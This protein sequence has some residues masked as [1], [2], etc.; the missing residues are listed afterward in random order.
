[1]LLK[2]RNLKKK[3]WIHL[4]HDS[5]VEKIG[6]CGCPSSFFALHSMSHWSYILISVPKLKCPLRFLIDYNDI[7]NSNSR[8]AIVGHFCFKGGIKSLN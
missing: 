8:L 7:A 4:K 3:T 2:Y 5:Q 1:M 6:I